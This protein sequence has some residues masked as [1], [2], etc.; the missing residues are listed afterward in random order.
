MMSVSSRVIKV[1]TNVLLDGEYSRSNLAHKPIFS[2]WRLINKPETQ[3]KLPPGRLMYRSL[4]PG[5]LIQTI[6]HQHSNVIT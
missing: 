1:R 2:L 4:N 3:F 5:T 6:V